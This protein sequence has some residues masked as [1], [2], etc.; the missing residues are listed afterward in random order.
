ML[1][2]FIP[3]RSTVG[4]ELWMGNR[5]GATGFLDESQFPLFNRWE[6]DQYAA[7]G[8]VAYM[9]D[10]AALA[11]AYMRAH[12]GEFLRLSTIRLIRFWTGTGTHDGSAI[13]A[14]HAVLT[15]TLGWLGMWR[16]V[17]KRRFSL[18]ALLVLPLILFPLPYY[19]THAEFRYRLVVDPLLTMLAGYAISGAHECVEQR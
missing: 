15:S 1:H 10:K 17:R 11:R 4:L 3:L 8:E 6:Y 9:R 14:L 13:F 18:A 7:K 5:A 16:L 19:I 12:P 2:A